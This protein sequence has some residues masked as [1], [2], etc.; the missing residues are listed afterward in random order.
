MAK[1]K[2]YKLKNGDVGGVIIPS[3]NKGIPKDPTNTDWQ[4][5]LEWVEA[6]NTTDPAVEDE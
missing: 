4:E 6:G 5:Y 3:E 2:F 1:Y